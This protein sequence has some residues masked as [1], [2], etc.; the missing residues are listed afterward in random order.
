MTDDKSKQAPAT[1][2]DEEISDE[3]LKKVA[4]GTGRPPSGDANP[5]DLGNSTVDTSDI[6]DPQRAK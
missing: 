3:N 1:D 6:I 5:S 2:K 4:G